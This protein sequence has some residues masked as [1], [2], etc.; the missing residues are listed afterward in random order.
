MCNCNPFLG[1]YYSNN[2]AR[3][4][5]GSWFDVLSTQFNAARANIGA[6]CMFGFVPMQS[7]AFASPNTHYAFNNNIFDNIVGEWHNYLAQSMGQNQQYGMW[8][9]MGWYP[10]SSTRVVG[11]GDGSTAKTV[12]EIRAETKYDKLEKFVNTLLEDGGLNDSEKAEITAVKQATYATTQAK[13]DAL[14]AVLNDANKVSQD[15]IKNYVFNK[16]NA[17]TIDNIDIPT[18]RSKI[19]FEENTALDA[20]MANLKEEIESLAEDDENTDGTSVFGHLKLDTYNVLDVISSYNSAYTDKGL[21][22]LIDEKGDLAETERDALV[23]KLVLEANTVSNE[24]KDNKDKE[25]LTGL[26]KALQE[27]FSVENFNNLYKYTRY[28]AALKLSTKLNEEYGEILSAL[29]A[30]LFVDI[31]IED[32]AGEKRNVTEL[33]T[34]NRK[35]AK[36]QG[37]PNGGSTDKPE[38]P[39]TNEEIGKF[40]IGVLKDREKDNS[41]T[42]K[43]IFAFIPEED[44]EI[45]EEVKT[46]LV[47]IISAYYK[48]DGGNFL[49]YIELRTGNV[50]LIQKIIKIVSPNASYKNESSY[51]G[52]NECENSFKESVRAVNEAE[53]S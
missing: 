13:L 1:H 35:K 5:G 32:L 47:E 53:Q 50:E 22:E 4:T 43:E 9:T 39:E 45:T 17:I 2:G 8:N 18:L 19:G 24:V 16:G 33:K 20:E 38:I 26:V 10:S 6:R 40:L 48:N 28:Y 29:S 15:K 30:N 31:T 12:D 51:I 52:L 27:D 42:I 37:K 14:K 36:N 23:N 49:H 25:K 41:A 7:F 46:K 44:E 11:G 21:I 34:L 3:L